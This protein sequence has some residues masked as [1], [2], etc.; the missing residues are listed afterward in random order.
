MTYP[1]LPVL[2]IHATGRLKKGH[3]ISLIFLNRQEEHPSDS[4]FVIGGWKPDGL[5]MVVRNL[6][7]HSSLA[8]S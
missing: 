5:R 2:I 8:S 4:V 7:I 3:T 6:A 1:K